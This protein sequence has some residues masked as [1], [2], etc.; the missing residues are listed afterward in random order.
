MENIDQT[1]PLCGES[2]NMGSKAKPLYG[3]AVCIKCSNSFSGKRQLAYVIDTF[4][5]EIC[6]FILFALVYVLVRIFVNFSFN[7]SK[8]PSL[9]FVLNISY[10]LVFFLKDGFSKSSPGKQIMGLTVVDNT[11]GQ[12]I[13][14][15]TS[16]KRNLPL[17]IPFMPIIVF[18]ELY[19][20]YRIGD[21]WANTRVIWRKYEDKVPFKIEDQVI[22]ADFDSSSEDKNAVA[23]KLLTTEHEKNLARKKIRENISLRNKENKIVCPR[24]KEQN[25]RKDLQDG[26]YC[27]A[28]G[29]RL[30]LD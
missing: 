23:V 29:K 3:Q 9:Y 8:M 26:I 2:E 24:C 11:T 14:F 6:V 20:G 22:N 17:L 13:G 10:F 15:K 1:C 18:C 28:C 16:F 12:P 25:N 5:F 19:K 27:G 30:D 4:V 21:K 7:S